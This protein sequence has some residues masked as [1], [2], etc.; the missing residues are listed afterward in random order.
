[1]SN[2]RRRPMEEHP[3]G[4]GSTSSPRSASSGQGTQQTAQA[5]TRP[6]RPLPDDDV[7]LADLA[8]KT[9]TAPPTHAEF[10]KLDAQSQKEVLHTLDQT[11]NATSEF[12]W[13]E[14]WTVAVSRAV[15]NENSVMLDTWP[16]SAL[17]KNISPEVWAASGLTRVIGDHRLWALGTPMASQRATTAATKWKAALNAEGVTKRRRLS[18]GDRFYVL[19][20][21]CADAYRQ[22]VIQHMT[23]FTAWHLTVSPWV[24]KEAAVALADWGSADW[25][26]MAG[27]DVDLA[28]R[29]SPDL[30]M[31]Q[32][33]KD[34][35]KRA[36]A[37]SDVR[38]AQFAELQAVDDPTSA[39]AGLTREPFMMPA[40]KKKILLPASKPMA[41]PL[42][43]E[44]ADKVS[45]NDLAAPG[46]PS[47]STTSGIPRPISCGSLSRKRTPRAHGLA[48]RPS[49]PWAPQGLT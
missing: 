6:R 22:Q 30:V 10:D 23:T 9:L 8:A 13:A 47:A 40:A 29:W 34:V 19:V 33:L 12:D 41:L 44:G 46:H 32:L 2:K 24:T 16:P 14:R 4:P 1:M 38:I 36:S 37:A 48:S 3:S 7:L 5:S 49:R 11:Q 31:Q 15:A 28:S 21:Q 39:P 45:A 25:R 43:D 18:P 42:L 27:I 35:V 26:L 17:K 20:E